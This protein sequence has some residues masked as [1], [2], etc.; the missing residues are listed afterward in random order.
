MC[1]LFTY[2]LPTIC[3]VF[4]VKCKFE[5]RNEH[6]SHRSSIT[7]QGNVAKKV[8]QEILGLRAWFYPDFPGK[9]SLLFV[10]IFIHPYLF[11]SLQ[12]LP[13]SSLHL[14][15]Y[16]QF[17]LLFPGSIPHAFCFGHFSSLLP[18]TCHFYSVY[19]SPSFPHQYWTSFWLVSSPAQLP[20]LNQ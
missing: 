12:F 6:K 5:W 18:F 10:V 20:K 1:K 3:C 16:L 17:H 14:L 7:N 13:S 9:I 8:P 2:S 15:A 4:S 19:S 11:L